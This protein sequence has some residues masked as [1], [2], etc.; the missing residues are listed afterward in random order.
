[1]MKTVSVIVTTYNS[2]K[3]YSKDLRIYFSQNGNGVEF[4]IE[5]LVVDDCSTDNTRAILSANS[6]PFLSTGTNSGGPNKRRN[7]ALQASSGDYICIADHDDLWHS[8][9]IQSLCRF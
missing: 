8:N 7:I 4:K 6:I 5:L 9:K 2:R 3:N 1:M